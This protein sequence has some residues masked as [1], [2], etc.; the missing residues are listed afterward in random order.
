M[1]TSQ[2]VS[3][4]NQ[5]FANGLRRIVREKLHAA[6]ISTVLQPF[7]KQFSGDINFHVILKSAL[8]NS[9]RSELEMPHE[10]LAG[11]FPPLGGEI[12]DYYILFCRCSSSVTAQ[13]P[14]AEIRHRRFLGPTQL[15]DSARRA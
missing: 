15:T 13:E 14:D 9:E 11:Q 2:Q 7:R 3:I 5:A 10:P 6:Y 1:S 8:T 12:D 4:I